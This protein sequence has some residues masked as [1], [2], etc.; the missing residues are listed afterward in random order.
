ME[1]GWG[2]QMAR[3]ENPSGGEEGARS[4][5]HKQSGCEHCREE[6]ML[7]NDVRSRNV[8]ENKGNSDKFPDAMS[9]N[10]ACL[11]TIVATFVLVY[12]KRATYVPD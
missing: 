3:R 10:C 7:K 4:N 9:G 6:K 11:S 5:L 12:Q 8:Y 1:C 2:R